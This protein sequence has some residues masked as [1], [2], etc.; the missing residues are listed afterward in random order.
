M[1]GRGGGGEVSAT[2]LSA[3]CGSREALP[4]KIPV[5]FLFDPVGSEG[6]VW[7]ETNCRVWRLA[8]GGIPKDWMVGKGPQI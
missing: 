3:T 5:L 4:H 8:A 1:G 2:G 7:G 6:E